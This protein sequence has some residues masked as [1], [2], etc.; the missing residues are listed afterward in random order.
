MKDLAPYGRVAQN[1]NVIIFMGKESFQRASDFQAYIPF[2]FCLP[3]KTSPTIFHWS[4]KNCDV[5]LVDTDF[6]SSSF[7]EFCAL[8]FFSCGAK[9][10]KYI[11]ASHSKEFIYE[12]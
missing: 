6:S 12:Q 7:I 9:N 5:Y 10:M 1:E 4:L 11:C 2:T 8:H 3:F